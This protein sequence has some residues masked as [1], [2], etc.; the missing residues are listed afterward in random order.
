ME[1]KPLIFVFTSFYKPW[2]GGAEL[3]AS[4]IMKRLSDDFEFHI[5]THRLN[6]ALPILEKDGGVF[7]HRAGFG[8]MLDRTTIFPF[9][10]AM[11]VFTLLKNYP[12]RKKI[13]WGM[14]IS[15]ASIGAYF[16]KF[17]KKDIPFL[18]T[19]QEGDNEW[20]KHY[21]TWRIVLKKADRVIAISSFLAGVVDKAGYRGLVDIIPNG[22]NERLWKK[23]HA[24]MPRLVGGQ[25]V[26][27][28]IFSASRL[29]EKNGLDIL[30]RAATKI[31]DEKKIRVIIAGEGKDR[32]KLEKLRD[33]LGL[34]K[35]VEF[36]GNVPYEKLLKL[37]AASDIFVR[38]SR[39]EGLGSAFLEAMA[40]G[41]I[42]VG[43]STGGITD[44]LFEG[45]TGF[46]A[47]PN[48]EE[49][50]VKALTVALTLAP[51]KKEMMVNNA[52]NLVKEKFLWNDVA[53]KM[54][55]VFNSQL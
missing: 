4:E 21:F 10:A 55:E 2:M 17:I 48:D 7:I 29:V 27:K 54:K 49:S 28:I 6:F 39:S 52:R 22:V 15:Y 1:E 12:G 24:E 44:F 31:G 26:E 53:L 35:K 23:K 16:L 47:K 34:Q 36:L 40:A 20:K 42:T 11:K 43:I 33:D 19:I 3:A 9:L 14:M 30:F 5:I 8:T 50:L 13:F 38:P 18:L 32:K 45:K 41:L 37:Y 51:E 46:L 25:A